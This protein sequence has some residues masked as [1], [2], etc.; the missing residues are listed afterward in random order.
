MRYRLDLAYDGTDFF[1][2][3][4]QPGLRT[5]EETLA[6]WVA[7]V[8][9]LDEPARLIVAGRTDAGVHATGQV[10]HFDLPDDFVVTLRTGESSDVAAVLKHRLGRVL[11]DDLIVRGV[12]P[13]S[14]D[15]DARFSATFRRYTYRLWDDLGIHEP[16]LRRRVAQVRGVLD[17]EAMN[18]AAELLLGLH[19]FAAFCKPRKGATTIRTLRQLS[20]VRDPVG[21]VVFT[22]VADAFCHSM[23]RSLMGAIVGVGQ[24]EPP[25]KG[26]IRRDQDWVAALL[27]A[28]VRDSTVL[29]MPASGLTLSE[30]GYPTDDQLAV[31]AA[32]S[33]RRREPHEAQNRRAAPDEIDNDEAD[34]DET[35][36]DE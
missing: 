11:P 22:V 9:R 36:N 19:D 31:R 27:A 33:R 35:D 32:E 29:M 1:G 10:C 7:Q 8:L 17:V 26:R 4:T 21:T 2:W 14:D 6:T 18:T 3:A 24:G 13:V 12:R 16:T 15:F 30:V 25:R 20:G 34:N 5:V 28:A 23:V